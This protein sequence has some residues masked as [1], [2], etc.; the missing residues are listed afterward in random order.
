M[1]GDPWN[2]RRIGANFAP[3]KRFFTTAKEIN[4]EGINVDI[5]S[6]TLRGVVLNNPDDPEGLVPDDYSSYQFFEKNDLVFKLIDLENFKTS[7]VGLVP[8]D[9]IMSPA[10]IR[11]IPGESINPR[12]AYWWF[13]FLYLSGVYNHL[14]AG[15][16]ANLSATELLELD[17]PVLNYDAQEFIA[18]KIDDFWAIN[19]DVKL[20]IDKQLEYIALYLGGKIF[21]DIQKIKSSCATKNLRYLLEEITTGSTPNESA[22]NTNGLPWYS[23]GSIDNFGNLSSPS[24]YVLEN[25]DPKSRFRTY[26]YPSVMM[27][28]VGATA[29]KVAHLDHVATSN[30]QITCLKPNE[31][32]DSRFLFYYLLLERPNILKQANYTTIPIINNEFIKSLPITVPSVNI[33]KELVE[34]WTQK[35]SELTE[36]V[37]ALKAF[38]ELQTSL[39]LSQLNTIFT[40]NLSEAI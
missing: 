17:F 31:S 15:V 23:P 33:Q 4:S 12:F 18:K 39:F 7:R 27:V 34:V 16:R 2:N 26:G 22:D 30:Q 37:V 19:S 25:D 14:G 29:G 38:S 13:Y 28:G 21:Q 10:Y 5:L 8:R 1:S 36:L 24:R 6:L 20:N 32:L 11:L 9:G 3:A 40:K 35:A